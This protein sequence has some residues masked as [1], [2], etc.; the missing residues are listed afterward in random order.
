MAGTDP[1]AKHYHTLTGHERCVLSLEAMARHDDVEDGRLEATC[2]RYHYTMEDWE[3]RSRMNYTF[4]AAVL[5]CVEI[6]Q[7]LARLHLIQT[8]A[9]MQD[10]YEHWPADIAEEAFYTGL[11]SHRQPADAAAEES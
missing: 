4:T 6:K 1:L 7:P 11:Y 9:D 2:P 8:F 5:P 3:F 10:V